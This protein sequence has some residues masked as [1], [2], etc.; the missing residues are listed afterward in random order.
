MKHFKLLSMLLAAASLLLASC[1]IDNLSSTEI[2][3]GEE[4]QV[5][6]NVKIPSVMSTRN[7]E[8]EVD[9]IEP[10]PDAPKPEPEPEPEPEKVLDTAVPGA[11]TQVSYL[12]YFV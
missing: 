6:L 7:G 5:T 1:S 12:R 9:P 10:D 2:A 8:N 4:Y 11:A 3:D